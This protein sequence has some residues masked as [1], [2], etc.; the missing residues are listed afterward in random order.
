M[1]E[2]GLSAQELKDALSSQGLVGAIQLVEDHVG[3]TFPAGSVE[4]VTAF[5]KIMGGATG[6]NV[7]L[8]LGGEHMKTYEANIDIF[9]TIFIN[10]LP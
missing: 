8:M 5:K 7:A 10:L 3:R 4:A 9:F 2:V 1:K 6:Y